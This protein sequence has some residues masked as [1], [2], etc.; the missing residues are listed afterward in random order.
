MLQVLKA[1]I[2]GGGENARSG[3]QYKLCSSEKAVCDSDLSVYQGIDRKGYPIAF[4][5]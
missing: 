4:E 1:V 2:L 5:A 3:R